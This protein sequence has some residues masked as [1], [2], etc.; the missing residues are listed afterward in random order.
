MACYAP[1]APLPPSRLQPRGDLRRA[2]QPAGRVPGPTCSCSPSCCPSPRPAAR[3]PAGGFAL[4]ACRGRPRQPRHRPAGLRRPGAAP[5]IDPGFLRDAADL[6]RLEAGLAMIRHAAAGAAFA[7]LGRQRG[8]ARPRQSATAAA[9]GTGSGARSA[10]TTT[11]PAP[12]GSDRARTTARSPTPQLRVHGIAGLRVA[13]A[14]VMPSIPNAPPHATVLAI[15]EN[16]A[17][18]ITGVLDRRQPSNPV[19]IAGS[20]KAA[21]SSNRSAQRAAAPVRREPPHRHDPRR[22]AARRSPGSSSSSGSAATSTSSTSSSAASSSTIGLTFWWALIAIAVGTADRRAADRPARH[23][24]A[25]ARRAADHPVP[26]PV[27]LLRGG[28]HVPRRPAA[29]RRVHRRRA[30][31]PGPGHAPGVHLRR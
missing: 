20:R 6:D 4:V 28:V 17:A 5:L 21:M 11:R 2:A 8:L 23:P 13:D 16:A 31:H 9:C 12:A 29:Q 18:L 10:A 27:R 19:P 30:G 24:G 14:S 26:R 22:G 7:R 3:H 25:P 15:A 1:A